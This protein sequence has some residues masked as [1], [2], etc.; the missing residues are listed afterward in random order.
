MQ[1]GKTHGE[2]EAVKE[3]FEGIVENIH[4]ETPFCTITKWNV[5]IIDSNRIVDLYK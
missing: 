3:G 4:A 1:A 2:S 5:L